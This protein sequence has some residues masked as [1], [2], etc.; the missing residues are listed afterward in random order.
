MQREICQQVKSCDASVLK[1]GSFLSSK[2]YHQ[3][4]RQVQLLSIVS[5]EPVWNVSAKSKNKSER[6]INN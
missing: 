2:V 3:V 5:V 1:R 6:L 4:V